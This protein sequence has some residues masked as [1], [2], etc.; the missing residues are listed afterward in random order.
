MGRKRHCV[1]TQLDATAVKNHVRMRGTQG[2][3]E[4][5]SVMSGPDAST[6]DVEYIFATVLLHRV[7]LSSL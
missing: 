4:M 2:T 7:W 6:S 1:G 3:Q 5:M